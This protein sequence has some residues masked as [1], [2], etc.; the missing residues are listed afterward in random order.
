MQAGVHDAGT[1]TE[2]FRIETNYGCTDRR[3]QKEITG[4]GMSIANLKHA[5]KATAPI[6]KQAP[7]TADH[8]FK[9]M[10]L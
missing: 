6:P 5:N 2:S 4:N 9:H 10:R 3:S 7:P 8:A 1:L